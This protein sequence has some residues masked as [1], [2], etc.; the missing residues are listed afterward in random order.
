MTAT[1]AQHGI[2][3]T[4]GIRMHIV[5]QGSGPT[6]LLCRGFPEC[7]YSWRHQLS[8]LAAADFHAV[9]P[10]MRGYGQTDALQEIDRYTLLHL[11]GDMVGLLDT[12]GRASGDRRA[13]LG[14]PGGVACGEVAPRPLPGGN[15]IE[16][17]IPGA[18]KG[19]ADDRHA[20]D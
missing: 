10:D 2:V 8:A 16:R 9:A 3:E 12:L 14:R 19:A 15:R 7:W 11:L 4:N 13:R 5:E 1:Q 18:R 6:V 20:A 17:A